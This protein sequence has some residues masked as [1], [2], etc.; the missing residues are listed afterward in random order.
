MPEDVEVLSPEELQ[1]PND[2]QAQL[3][4]GRKAAK[5]LEAE[6]AKFAALEKQSAIDKAGVPEHPAR[7]VVFKDYDGPL[8]AAFAGTHNLVLPCQ[9][10]GSKWEDPIPRFKRY[11]AA[12]G[13]V[14]INPVGDA[15]SRYVVLYKV[16]G[17]R[18]HADQRWSL[19]LEAFRAGVGAG[20]PLQSPTDLQIG[21]VIIPA[22]NTQGDPG[23]RMRIRYVPPSMRPIP[24]VSVAE[25]V[26]N[27]SLARK[28]AGKV[29][30]AGV[31]DQTEARDRWMTP[32]SD[33]T[34]MAGIE[35][36]ANIYETIANRLFLID[37]PAGL[38]FLAPLLIVVAAGLIWRFTG[39]ITAPVLSLALLAVAHTYQVTSS[40]GARIRIISARPATKQERIFYADDPR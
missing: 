34:P 28:F 24:S 32:L 13:E 30:F 20:A 3:R 6:R 16:T 2:V 36:N 21:D 33:G 26:A 25:L 11:A 5:E 12:V 15:V 14:Y 40:S 37:A 29:V 19:S 8:E 9:L 1:L 27:P 7:E 38:W 23:Y 4:I 10:N 22:V 35:M 18:G 31:S 39:G 17:D